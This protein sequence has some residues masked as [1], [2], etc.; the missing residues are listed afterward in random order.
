M[1]TGRDGRRFAR[2]GAAAA[3]L[4]V[5]G[6]GSRFAFQLYTSH[7]GADA[8]GRLSIAHGIPVAT[9]SAT[10]TAALVLMAL[11]EVLS[12]TGVLAMRAY[13]IGALG[14]GTVPAGPGRGTARSSTHPA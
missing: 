7:G 5:H 9:I 10:W 12:R 4:W 11:G 2:A 3:A 6:V 8:V 1:T 14:P 13:R